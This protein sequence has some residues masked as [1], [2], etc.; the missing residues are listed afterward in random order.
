MGTIREFHN[1]EDISLS[2]QSKRLQSILKTE[3]KFY[4]IEKVKVNN[5]DLKS[6]SSRANVFSPLFGMAVSKLRQE[7]Y[8]IYLD[9][10]R[11]YPQRRI[12]RFGKWSINILIFRQDIV[13]K[14]FP[15][16]NEHLID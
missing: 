7:I 15:F 12:L 10:R 11:N 6:K 4:G 5:F 2:L 14:Y 1:S 8:S 16:M 3:Q 13:S 9:F